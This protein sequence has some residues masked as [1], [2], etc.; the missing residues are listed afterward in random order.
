M[1]SKTAF[2]TR[3]SRFL[4][5]Q[6][7]KNALF[8]VFRP[9]RGPRGFKMRISGA[10]YPVKAFLSLFSLPRPLR[11]RVAGESGPLRALATT[12][13]PNPT[14]K[15]E[16]HTQPVCSPAFRLGSKMPR[17]SLPATPAQSPVASAKD[18]FTQR[19]IRAG[20]RNRLSPRANK[21][22]THHLSG[23]IMIYSRLNFRRI[24]T[25]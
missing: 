25:T 8:A 24:K 17:S 13:S 4:P 23:P 9:R 3:F 10:V 18:G 14:L 5:L 1:W 15:R 16:L 6:A 12:T 21:E 2:S 7:P 19:S 20:L 11:P 22:L